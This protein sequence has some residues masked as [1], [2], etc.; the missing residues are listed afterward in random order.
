MR[1]SRRWAAAVLAAA[2]LATGGAGIAADASG[3]SSARTAHFDLG[4]ACAFPAGAVQVTVAITASFPASAAAGQPIQPITAQLSVRLP[5]PAVAELAF[6]NARSVSVAAALTVIQG[7][8][9]TSVLDRWRWPAASGGAWRLPDSGPM[10]VSTPAAVQAGT[11]P[12]AGP[13]GFTAS[14]LVLTFYP[15]DTGAKVARQAAMGVSC[16]PASWSAS[17][18]LGSVP[19]TGTARARPK[20]PRR[21]K[22]PKGCADIP[23]YGTG[24]PACAYIT[25]F[26]DVAKLIGAALLQPRPPARPGLVNVAFA[27]E[28]AFKPN[29][30]I[31]YSTARLYYK[32]NAELPPVTA[33]FLAFRFIPVTA[34]LHIIEVPLIRIVSVSQDNSLPYRITVTATTKVS[35]RVSNV[36][37]NGLPLNVG[38]DCRTSS[39]VT[40]VL[41]GRGENA[42]PPTGYTVETGGPLSGF[43]TVPPFIGCGV[44]ENLDPLL[45][46]SISGRGNFVKQTQGKLCGPTSQFGVCP[47][48]A[49][50]PER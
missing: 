40:L 39:L 33:T 23:V 8:H 34:T 1:L 25:G 28:H 30:L 5:G 14:Q 35:I 29:E 19:V 3:A 44:T 22:A 45:T 20:A 24:V 36:N 4:Y 21:L 17:A 11:A 6:G 43:I 16:V 41:V 15:A 9:G 49:P 38:A 47:P 50:K 26:A 46:G 18:R 7:S 48:L 42:I 37:V 2:V 32:G 31:E 13:V 27:E 12:T 10:T